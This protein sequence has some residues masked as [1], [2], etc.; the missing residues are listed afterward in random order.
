MPCARTATGAGCSARNPSQV[1]VGSHEK[2][3][4]P[5]YESSTVARYGDGSP[6]TVEQYSRDVTAFLAWAADPSLEQRKSM[7]WIVLLYLAITSILLFFAKKRIWAD[8]H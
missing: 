4:N 3:A 5:R 2:R 6:Q 8:A 1:S 7:G